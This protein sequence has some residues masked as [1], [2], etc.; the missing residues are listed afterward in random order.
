MYHTSWQFLAR[1]VVIIQIM[2]TPDPDNDGAFHP[3]VYQCKDIV[4][5]QSP[6]R[7]TLDSSFAV[8]ST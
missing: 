3:F 1:S 6:S 4:V 7:T 2:A 5:L 8:G